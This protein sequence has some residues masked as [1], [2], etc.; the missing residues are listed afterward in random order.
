MSS[1]AEDNSMSFTSM[2]I[3]CIIIILAGMVIIGQVVPSSAV[4]DFLAGKSSSLNNDN[5]NQKCKRCGTYYD[6]SG[7]YCANCRDIMRKERKNDR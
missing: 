2:L 4:N 3:W 5:N 1:Y 7:G 6:V